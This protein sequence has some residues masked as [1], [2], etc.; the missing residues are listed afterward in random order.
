MRPDYRVDS[1]PATNTFAS[2]P[3]I[4]LRAVEEGDLEIFF[5][6]Q[7]D[8]AARQRAQF[9]GRARDE[10]MAHWRKIR[11]DPKCV[12]RTIVLD[13]VVT[14]NVVSWESYGARNIGYWLGREHWGLGI[15][16]AAVEQFLREAPDRPLFAHVAKANAASIRV[17]EK[18]GF[19]KVDDDKFVGLDG[20]EAIEIVMRL[21]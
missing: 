1:R 17:L 14:G 21:A 9:P 19:V 18:C 7:A 10:F 16:S 2:M 8:E 5:A 13:G 15:A 4:S 6:Q 20:E 11:G 12:L 3:A